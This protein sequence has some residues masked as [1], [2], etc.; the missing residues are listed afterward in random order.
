M[1]YAAM[2]PASR[3]LA[4]PLI[5]GYLVQSRWKNWL[6]LVLDTAL[7]LS[8]PF[9]RKGFPIP[10]PRRILLC[11]GAHLGDVLVS[12]AV[13][14]V[15]KE[16]FPDAEI[17]FL[18]GS[19]GR[20]ILEGNPLVDRIHVVDHA[21]LNRSATGLRAKLRRHRETA[22]AAL[23][24]IREARYDAAID[25]YCH[26]GNSISLLRRA[27][28]P[29]RIGYGTG[30]FGPLLS[31]QAEWCYT[32]RHMAEYQLALLRFLPSGGAVDGAAC[33]PAYLLPP[34][35]GGTPPRPPIA[36]APGSYVV[37]H[38]GTGA[39]MKEWPLAKWRDLAERLTARGLSLCFTG[40]GARETENATQ[41]MEGLPGAENWC[42]R[43]SW[44]EFL[45]TLRG[46]RASVCTDSLAAHLTAALDRPGVV[47]STGLVNPRHWRPLSAR[48]LAVVRETPCAPCFRSRGCEGMECVREVTVEQVS[49]A[50]LAAMDGTQAL[51]V[52]APA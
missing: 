1:R 45:A 38:M 30:G 17:G 32:D 51:P 14:P 18:I 28:I 31:H 15:L 40:V 49:E 44:V 48:S 36:A 29:V 13:L 25:L 20:P 46:C 8:R 9:A 34:F 12:T 23:R 7:A 6:L 37:V 43:L 2:I 50:L 39:V 24:G 4:S 22:R 10:P 35:P 16:R 41:V 27:G 47:I 52:S 42:G 5:G 3:K 26:V 19:W 11:N 21:Y 33:P